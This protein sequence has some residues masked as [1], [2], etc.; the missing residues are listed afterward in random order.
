MAATRPY[1]KAILVCVTHAGSVRFSDDS[2]LA[3]IDFLPPV[4]SARW[5]SSVS[6]LPIRPLVHQQLK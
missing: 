1:A 3:G 6:V 2:A 5:S 4:C